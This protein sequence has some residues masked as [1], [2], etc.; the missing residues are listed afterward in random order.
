MKVYVENEKQQVP[1]YVEN[2]KQRV[3]VYVEMRSN[4]CQFT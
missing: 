1:V 3:P 4:G 2:E